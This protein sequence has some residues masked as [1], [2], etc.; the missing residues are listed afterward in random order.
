MFFCGFYHIFADFF[1]N[2]PV[3]CGLFFKKSMILVSSDK[4]LQNLL[5]SLSALAALDA[6]L[7]FLATL[8]DFLTGLTMFSRSLSR[9]SDLRLE[10]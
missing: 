8:R 9:S 7:G 5:Y 4:P 6:F 3:F 10:W 1:L 2:V